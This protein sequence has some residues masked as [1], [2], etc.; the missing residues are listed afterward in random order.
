MIIDGKRSEHARMLFRRGFA[1]GKHAKVSGEELRVKDIVDHHLRNYALSEGWR[2]RRL[3]ALRLAWTEGFLVGN[4]SNNLEELPAGKPLSIVVWIKPSEERTRSR[5]CLRVD[6]LGQMYPP[7]HSTHCS[8]LPLT[9]EALWF[10][11]ERGGV[12]DLYTQMFGPCFGQE[13]RSCSIAQEK[14]PELG[15]TFQ[16]SPV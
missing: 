2:Y 16:R 11:Y 15:Q 7:T 5:N 3:D 10:R 14:Y 1:V 6:A 12:L 4:C 13:C 8:L 9:D